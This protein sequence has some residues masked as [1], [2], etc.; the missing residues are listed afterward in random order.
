MLIPITHL[1]LAY[2]G[3]KFYDVTEKRWQLIKLLSNLFGAMGY[4]PVM[5]G[6]REQFRCSCMFCVWELKLK[7]PF[8]EGLFS[9]GCYAD[10]IIKIQ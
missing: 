8:A 10:C 3:I 5:R 7:V 9:L 2:L 1:S 4:R 6:V